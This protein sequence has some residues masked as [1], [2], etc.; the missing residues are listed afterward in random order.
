MSH[1]PTVRTVRHDINTKPFIVIWEVT[2]A[3][4]LVCKHCRAD[5]QHHANPRQLSTEDG[6]K[7]LDA[8][9]SYP[10]PYPLVVLTGGDPC[11]REDLEQLV[12][13][14]TSLGLNV[15]ISPS[16]TPKLTPERISSLREAGAKAMSMS[17]D[18]ATA[19]THDSFRGFPGTFDATLALAPHV[20]GCGFRLQINSTLTRSNLHEAPALLKQVIDMGAHMWYTFFLV[21]TGRGTQL[22]SLSPTEREDVL[23]WLHDVSDRIAIKTTEAPQYRRVALQRKQPDYAYSGGDLYQQ[24]TAQTHKLLGEVPVKPRR[25]RPPMAVNSGSGFAFIDHIGDVYPQ[26]LPATALW[27]RH[28]HLFRRHLRTLPRIPEPPRP[29]PLGRQVQRVR[30]PHCLRRFPLDRLRNDRQLPSLRSYLFIRAARLE[31]VQLEAFLFAHMYPDG[32]GMSAQ[33]LPPILLWGSTLMK[34]RH[35]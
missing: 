10:R 34:R 30:I 8:L 23:H 12:E 22:H 26:R 4:A 18:G 20:V 16:V 28:R 33:C 24:L 11:E 31:K 19:A 27:K 5:A 35:V 13:Y 6:L 7:L 21:P 15:S 14:G 2:R 29:R 3:C 1:A 17:L 25:P 9:A 32:G